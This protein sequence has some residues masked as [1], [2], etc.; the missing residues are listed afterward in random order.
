MYRVSLHASL[1][2]ASLDYYMYMYVE[3]REIARP[4]IAAYS[5][6]CTCEVA[7]ETK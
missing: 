5:T 2:H 3:K 6:T 4:H 1:D 7:E